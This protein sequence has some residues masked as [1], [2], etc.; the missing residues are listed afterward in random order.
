MSCS[1]NFNY[2]WGWKIRQSFEGWI[3]YGSLHFNRTANDIIP[4]RDTLKHSPTIFLLA[5]SAMV[6]EA[7]YCSLQA[8]W[9]LG[10]KGNFCKIDYFVCVTWWDQIFDYGCEQINTTSEQVNTFIMCCKFVHKPVCKL[11]IS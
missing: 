2:V 7:R 5:T 11:L 9:F 3:P 6:L 10:P 4:P 8:L 1:Q